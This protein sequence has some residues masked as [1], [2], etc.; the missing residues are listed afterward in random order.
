MTDHSHRNLQT[1][2]CDVCLRHGKKW[3]RLSVTA[4]GMRNQEGQG[5]KA[6]LG[7][8]DPV[9]NNKPRR[10]VASTIYSAQHWGCVELLL[11]IAAFQ[12]TV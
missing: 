11:N 1:R 6:N 3:W 12:V 5:F 7:Y 2:G 9:T 4:L 10:N 8:I